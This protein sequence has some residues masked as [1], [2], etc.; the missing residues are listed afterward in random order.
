MRRSSATHRQVL[1]ESAVHHGFYFVEGER[2]PYTCL[3]FLF[4]R[5]VL[6]MADVSDVPDTTWTLYDDAMAE[7][8]SPDATVNGVNGVHTVDRDGP[9]VI[10][11][12]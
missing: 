1:T 5:A 6:Y 4:D 11:D 3:A 12:W 9:V 8:Q 2:R 7:R 10:L